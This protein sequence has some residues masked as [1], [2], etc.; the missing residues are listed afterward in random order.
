MHTHL[1]MQALL[2]LSHAHTHTLRQSISL[3]T[4]EDQRLLWRDGGAEN[5]YKVRER[6][7]KILNEEIPVK[8]R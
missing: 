2:A 4:A 8:I 5:K 7:M 1:D 3:H 6:L